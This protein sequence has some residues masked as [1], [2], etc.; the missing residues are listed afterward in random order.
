MEPTASLTRNI[1]HIYTSQKYV[2]LYNIITCY[3]T[4]VYKLGYA[5]YTIGNMSTNQNIAREWVQYTYK[6]WKHEHSSP[7]ETNIQIGFINETYV[8]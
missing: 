6:E 5:S 2:R 3:Y 4:F 8:E 1:Q 7:N